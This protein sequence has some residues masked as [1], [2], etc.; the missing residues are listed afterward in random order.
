MHDL[1]MMSMNLSNIY[2]LN[3]KNV[4]YCCIFNV[5][6]NSEATKLLRNIDLTLKSQTL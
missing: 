4:D 2:I 6:S 5:I 3:I 1:L